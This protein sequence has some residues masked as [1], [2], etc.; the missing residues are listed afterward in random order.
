VTTYKS[1]LAILMSPTDPKVV[2]CVSAVL[3]AIINKLFLPSTITIVV[4]VLRG[5]VFS[6]YILT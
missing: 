6:T 3:N 4:I 5:E 1:I 2:A